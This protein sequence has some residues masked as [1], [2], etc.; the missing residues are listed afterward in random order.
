MSGVDIIEA[1]MRDSNRIL[2][3]SP[4]STDFHGISDVCMSVPTLLNRQGVNNY[5]QHPGL[6]QGARRLKRS[7]ETPRK[8]PPSSA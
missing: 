4:C 2:P 3:V 8:P 1:V 6:R 7:A 5:H